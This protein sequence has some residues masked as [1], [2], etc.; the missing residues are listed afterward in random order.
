MK[1]TICIRDAIFAIPEFVLLYLSLY[2]WIIATKGEDAT[3]LAGCVLLSSKSKQLEKNQTTTRETQKQTNEKLAG[4]ASDLCCFGFLEGLIKEI[5][6]GCSWLLTSEGH[7][8]TKSSFLFVWL[9]KL[10]QQAHSENQT[11]PKTRKTTN[12]L[13]P[14]AGPAILLMFCC[15]QGVVFCYLLVYVFSNCLLLWLVFLECL[16]VFE[17][18]EST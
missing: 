5:K 8:T 17:L 15:S 9:Q 4:L 7:E 3:A 16:L 13:K 12:N 10:K 18:L 11:K 6:H 1:R 2:S 14:E